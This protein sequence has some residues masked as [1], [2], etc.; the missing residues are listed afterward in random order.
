MMEGWWHRLEKSG[1]CAANKTAKI[2]DE[3]P[4]LSAFATVD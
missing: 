1:R 2:V 3:V 4:L